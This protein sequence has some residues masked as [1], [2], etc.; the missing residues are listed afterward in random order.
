MW[1]YL[2]NKEPFAFAG[3]WDMW[4]KPDGGKVESFTIITTVNAR[5]IADKRIILLGCRLADLLTRIL[6]N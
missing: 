6:G 3:L 4:R 5:R 1:V 2:K